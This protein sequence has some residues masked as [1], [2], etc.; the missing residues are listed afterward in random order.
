MAV[1]G[2]YYFL[3]MGVRLAGELVADLSFETAFMVVANGYTFGLFWYI[4]F[5]TC[6]MNLISGTKPNVVILW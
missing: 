6:S 2:D 5:V 3:E 1:S 4:M